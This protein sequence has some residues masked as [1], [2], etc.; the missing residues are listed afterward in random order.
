LYSTINEISESAE[1]LSYIGQ[2]IAFVAKLGKCRQARVAL[3]RGFP[4][5]NT[6][7]NFWSQAFIC[8]ERWREF[9]KRRG[10]LDASYIL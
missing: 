6:G 8:D 7:I 10:I 4:S 3:C 1:T 5:D 2:Y 9:C